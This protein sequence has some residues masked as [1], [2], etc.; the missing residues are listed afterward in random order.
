MKNK[1][2]YIL[3]CVLSAQTLL[4]E[5]MWIWKQGKIKTENADFQKT[6]NLDSVPKKA[7]LQAT[8]DNKFT[9]LIN[10]KKVVSSSNWENAV[11]TDVAKF[12][13][14]GEN[15]ILVNAWNEGSMAGFIF[16]LKMKGKSVSSDKSWQARAPKGEWAS[17]V[18]LKK[19]GAGP[20]GKV[21][22]KTSSKKKSSGGSNIAT[23]SSQINVPEG[24]KVERLYSVPKGEQGS[25]VE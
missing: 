25:W 17:A 3:L 21:F 19:Y 20:W 8:C 4:A 22:S 2:I 5:P 7:A 13:K 14:K 15:T 1:L 12:L 6:F 24:F 9:L 16:D 10:G 11:K 18:E 23:D